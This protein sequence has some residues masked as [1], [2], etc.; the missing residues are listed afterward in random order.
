MGTTSYVTLFLFTFFK[1]K[2]TV[3]KHDM[4]SSQTIEMALLRIGNLS[5]HERWLVSCSQIMPYAWRHV[6]L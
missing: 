6:S 5:H 2:K 3:M 4:T 1:K